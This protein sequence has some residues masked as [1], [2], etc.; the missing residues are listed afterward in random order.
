MGGSATDRIVGSVLGTSEFVELAVRF[1]VRE[2]LT[3][4]LM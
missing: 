2:M 1:E 4:P 3:V